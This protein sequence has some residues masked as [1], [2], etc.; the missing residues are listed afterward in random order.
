MYIICIII[1]QILQEVSYYL[2]R[3]NK[4]TIGLNR[5]GNY[6]NYIKNKRGNPSLR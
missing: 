6:D 3:L 1:N 2:T 5:V 4:N